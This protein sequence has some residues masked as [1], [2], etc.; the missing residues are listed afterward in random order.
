MDCPF[1]G[2]AVCEDGMAIAY[3]L[4][5]VEGPIEHICWDDDLV[6]VV[7]GK[8]ITYGGA[9]MADCTAQYDDTAENAH[10]VDRGHGGAVEGAK[11]GGDA[12]E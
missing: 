10:A 12:G 2:C 9:H 5:G 8:T 4:A 11:E 1:G 7:G 3:K 6:I